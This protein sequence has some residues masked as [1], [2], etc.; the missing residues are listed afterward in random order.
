MGPG[1]K[2][3]NTMGENTSS[4]CIS[5][6]ENLTLVGQVYGKAPLQ[7][8]NTDHYQGEYVRSFVQKWTS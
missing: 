8:R 1:R 3:D 5:P 6:H 4:P 2:E 7:V